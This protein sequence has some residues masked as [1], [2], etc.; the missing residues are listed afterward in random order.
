ME[1]LKNRK[2]P[3][4]IL[5]DTNVII[6][7]QSKPYGAQLKDLMETLKTKKTALIVPQI[8]ELELLKRS[9]DVGIFNDTI[10]Y[11]QD[12]FDRW[13]ISEDI[14][15]TSFILFILYRWNKK[16]SSIANAE[17]INFTFD[18]IV[19]AHSASYQHLNPKNEIFILSADS[20]PYP[21]PYFN[22][23]E[24]YKFDYPKKGT[25]LTLYLFSCDSK[26]LSE[27]KNK[28]NEDFFK[29]PTL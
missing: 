5:I 22:I 9:K 1:V 20:T 7:L 15:S 18:L 28:H 11:I 19:A 13:P 26:K 8:V 17:N 24:Q 3:I 21:T 12:N 4:G 27:D 23:V 6:Y 2:A 10:G 16:T 29:S 25:H 14:L